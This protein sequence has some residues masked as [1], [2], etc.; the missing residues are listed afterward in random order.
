MRGGCDVLLTPYLI[1]DS[2]NGD[3]YTVIAD[4][5]RIE[6]ITNV[7]LFCFHYI[8][9]LCGNSALHFYTEIR[10]ETDPIRFRNT[11]VDYV[12]E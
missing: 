11:S 3:C 4:V 12:F 9:L 7:I 10:Y 8:P 2:A 6:F 5:I 1:S